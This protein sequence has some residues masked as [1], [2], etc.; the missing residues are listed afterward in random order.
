AGAFIVATG[1]GDFPNQVNNSVCFPGLLKGVLLARA[2]RVTDGMAIASAH[3]LADFAAARGIGPDNIM[4]TMEET[5]VFPIQ[6]ARVAEE[7]KRS[8]LA[9]RQITREE[10]YGRAKAD[11]EAARAL[12]RRMQDEG[13][14]PAP[15]PALVRAALEEALRETEGL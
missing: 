12:Y 5:E 11:A 7:A 15:D 13:F 3:A 1:R 4:P 9:R 2:T 6:A 10:A 14:I 8:G